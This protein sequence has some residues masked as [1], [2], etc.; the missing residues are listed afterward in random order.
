MRFLTSLGAEGFLYCC[1]IA[2]VCGQI[3]PETFLSRLQALRQLSAP[4]TAVWS[5]ARVILASEQETEAELPLWEDDDELNNV[6]P[7]R[8]QTALATEDDDYDESPILRLIPAA[9]TGLADWEFH[10]G[11]PDPYPAVPHGHFI[12]DTPRKL[13]PYLGS[14]VRLGLPHGRVKRSRIVSLWND[15]DFRVFATQAIV[16]FMGNN[17]MWRWRVPHPLRLPRR[18]R[19]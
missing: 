13:D 6:P 10:K 15:Q 2:L 4:K 16:H 8:S 11:D 3:G 18:R 5:V 17:P 9:S 14:I 12:T 19:R 7:G 1:R